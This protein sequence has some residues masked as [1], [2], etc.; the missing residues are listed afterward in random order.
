MISDT[1][2]H[3]GMAPVYKTECLA[4]KSVCRRPDVSYTQRVPKLWDR[5]VAAH[6]LQVREAIVDA[7]AALV[8]E[9]GLRSVTMSRI[10]ERTGI[11][12]ATLYR[13]FPDVETILH[14]WHERQIA[15]HLQQLAEVRDGVGDPH[16][17]LEKVLEAYALTSLQVRGHH[18]ADLAAFLHRD[19]RI[20]RAQQELHGMIRDLL[21]EGQNLGAV[22]DD[23]EAGELASYCLHALTASGDAASRPAVHRLVAVTLTGLRPSAD[24]WRSRRPPV[25]LTGLF[26]D[27][28]PGPGNSEA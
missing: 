1:F 7:A 16:E 22:R 28:W 10:A 26:D 3:R 21:V 2:T 24:G 19:E 6:R 4:Y 17:R 25:N 27:P 13:Y 12:R 14:V 23:V 20:A 18:D 11:G 15:G 9:H 5:T 8:T